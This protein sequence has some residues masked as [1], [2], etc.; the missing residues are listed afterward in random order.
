MLG[1]NYCGDSSSVFSSRSSGDGVKIAWKLARGQNKGPLSRKSEDVLEAELSETW[2][3]IGIRG[4]EKILYHIS[5][6]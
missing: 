4:G 6:C 3:L 5:G 2:Q 1:S